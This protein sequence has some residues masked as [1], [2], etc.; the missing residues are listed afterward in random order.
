MEFGDTIAVHPPSR[1][2]AFDLIVERFFATAGSSG[3]VRRG[4]YAP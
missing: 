2:A 4:R 3:A 1:R